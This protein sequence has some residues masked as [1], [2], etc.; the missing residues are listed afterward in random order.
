MKK[1][2]NLF[3]R[4]LFRTVRFLV[5]LVYGKTK[6]IIGEHTP[7][8]HA[9]FVANHSQIHGPVVGELFMPKNCYIWCAGEIM[10]REEFPAYA[11]EVFWPSP[12]DKM[13]PV[14]ERIS[15][16]LAPLAACLFSN[17]RTVEVR[18]DY[19]IKKTFRESMELLDRGCTLMIFP[20]NDDPCNEILNDFHENFVNLARHYYKK[21]GISLSFV[22]VYNA[23][24]LKTTVVGEP[25]VYQAQNDRKAERR[26]I[27]SALS[28][29]ITRMARELPRHSVIPFKPTSE[30]ELPL[31]K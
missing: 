20:E 25:I 26:R 21:T 5:R 18:R 17:A 28:G 10:N 2:K 30:A 24:K 3:S 16:W 11:M 7:Q 22:P 29:E 12:S 31:N 14:C 27:V 4:A 9:V 23:P 6:V 15:R 1:K 13:R 19:R 8:T